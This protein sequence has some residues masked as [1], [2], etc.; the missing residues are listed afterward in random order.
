MFGTQKTCQ[1]KNT[2]RLCQQKHHT[3]LHENRNADE[4]SSLTSDDSAKKES[5]A[6]NSHVVSRM[7]FSKTSI[8]LAT[9]WIAVGSSTGSDAVVRALLDQGSVITLISERLA[10]R[11]RLERSRISITI[12][13]IGG[14]ASVAKNAARISV[15]PRNRLGPVLSVSAL[16]LKSL[17]NYVPQRMESLTDLEYLRALELADNDPTSAAPIDIIIGA[18]LYGSILRSGI[19]S[20]SPNEPVAQNSIFGWFISGSMPTQSNFEFTPLSTHH[21]SVHADLNDQ[22]KAFW[23]L[24]E[25]PRKTYLSPEDDWCEKHFASTHFRAPDGRYVVRLPFKTPPPRSASA[26]QG[27]RLSLCTSGQN[28][29]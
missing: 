1:R 17:T 9:A 21:C 29:A 26:N 7:S 10:Q 22:M 25:L 2:C 28:L 15:S 13:G 3:L 5:A 14:A 27:R 12:T 20:R 8:L 18:D 24:E 6:I 19:R 11:L 23:E 16:I 4:K